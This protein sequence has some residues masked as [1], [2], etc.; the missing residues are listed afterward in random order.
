MILSDRVNL[1]A[2]REAK[3]IAMDGTFDYSPNGFYQTYTM[4]AVFSD[5]PDKE[6]S[7]L[8]GKSVFNVELSNSNLGVFFISGKDS[9]DYEKVFKVIRHHVEAEFGD[10]GFEEKMVL[11]DCEP[12]VHIG[13]RKYFPTF[14]IRLCNFHVVKAM[15]QYAKKNGLSDIMSNENLLEWMGEIMGKRSRSFY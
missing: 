2:F 14:K 6:S 10:I 15:I 5:S 12:A 9:T 3:I 11:T 8:C 4:H 13:L 1:Q 7:F